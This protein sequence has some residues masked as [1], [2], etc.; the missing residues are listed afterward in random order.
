MSEPQIVRAPCK[1][2]EPYCGRAPSPCERAVDSE[3]TEPE[4]RVEKR[5]STKR[6]ERL[7]VLLESTASNERASFEGEHR[8]TRA[9]R[10]R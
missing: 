5:E 7:A 10:S 2:S 1:A 9:S 8:S 6:D 4:E 3:S